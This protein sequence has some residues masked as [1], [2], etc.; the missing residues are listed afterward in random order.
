MET[1]S[2]VSP[3][4]N[5]SSFSRM[6]QAS[7]DFL[8]SQEKRADEQENFTFPQLTPSCILQET[9]HSLDSK[10]PLIPGLDE[11]LMLCTTKIGTKVRKFAW[12]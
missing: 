1:V 8:L 9:L 10:V 7:S 2:S 6:L 11:V 4:K 12:R 3:V 5:S